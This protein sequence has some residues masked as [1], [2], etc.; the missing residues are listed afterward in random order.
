LQIVFQEYLHNIEESHQR[1]ER[2]TEEIRQQVEVWR[3]KPVVQSLQALRGISLVASAG[4]VSELG[5]LRRFTQARHLSSYIGLV[6]CEYSSGPH[7][8]QG[9]VTKTGNTHVRRLLIEAA[10]S[11]MR[12]PKVSPIIRQR[13][14]DLPQPIIDIAW[15]AQVRLCRR[16][17]RLVARGKNCKV[18]AVAV[19]RE[20]VAYIWAISNQVVLAERQML[21]A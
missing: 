10:W 6:P 14:Q 16:Y 19:A 3:W 12:G 13:Q 9:S 2:L 8:W 4:I 17:R 15:Q 18:A 21:A 11:Y 5:D 20:L 7:R 1:M